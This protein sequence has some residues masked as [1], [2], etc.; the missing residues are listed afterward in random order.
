MKD[1]QSQHDPRRIAI[2]KVGVKDIAYPITVL[3]KH[4]RVQHTVARVNMYVNLPHQFKGTHMSRFVEILNRFHGEIH[5][6]R[7]SSI[8]REMKE[9]LHAE[10]AHLEI[11][12]PYFL[13][14]TGRN[15]AGRRYL[16]AMHGS[17]QETEDLVIAVKVP[18]APPLEVAAGNGLPPSA[19]HWGL[20]D[21][22][23]RFGE[24]IWIEDLV[25]LVEEAIAAEIRASQEEGKALAVE[26]LTSAI[27]DRL[28]AHPACVWFTVTVEN[29]A[30]GYST[31]AT[32][33][34]PRTTASTNSDKA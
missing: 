34:W 1:I 33:E 11:D 31:F 8:L 21:V 6:K 14:Q 24:F 32:L 18:I 26:P 5:V 15:A 28:A 19:G 16:C 30:R 23:L 27:G 2:Q 25:T 3:D 13:P 4:T 12:F 7:F 22:R 29:Y 17:L 20:A 10:A 9:R